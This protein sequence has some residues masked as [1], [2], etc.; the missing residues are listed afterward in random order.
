MLRHRRIYRLFLPRLKRLTTATCWL[1]RS[2]WNNI[3]QSFLHP[4]LAH[5]CGHGHCLRCSHRFRLQ[6]LQH[7]KVLQMP[8]WKT[9][10]W[11]WDMDKANNINV[12][13]EAHQNQLLRLTH[14]FTL[15]KP[16]VT[17]SSALE[18][19]WRTILHQSIKHRYRLHNNNGKRH[20]QTRFRIHKVGFSSSLYFYRLNMKT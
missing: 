10:C 7:L 4:L 20:A 13:L 11:I 19:W 9:D 17:S 18:M 12:V 8:W 14:R 6:Q 3:G 1:K 2:Q 15:P 16:M 5:H